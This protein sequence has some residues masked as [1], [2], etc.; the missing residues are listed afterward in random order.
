MHWWFC[1][2]IFSLYANVYAAD[3]QADYGEASSTLSPSLKE[4]VHYRQDGDNLIG[5]IYVGDH[6]SQ[7]SQATWLYIKKALEYYKEKRPAFII[8]RLNTPGGQVY[9]AQQIADALRDID[10]KDNIPVVAFIDDWAL[11][12]GAMLAYA[13]RYITTTTNGSMGAAE[14]VIQSAEGKMESASEK[15]N[16]AMRADFANRARTFNRD[17]NIAEAMVDKDILLVWRQGKVVRLDYTDQVIKTGPDP[18]IVITPSGKLLTLNAIEMM[19]YGVADLLLKPRALPAITGA[20]EEKGAWPADKMLLF[21]YPFFKDIPNA[22][23]DEYKMDWKTQLFVWLASPVISSLLFMGLLLGFYIE[24]NTPGFGVAGVAA[25]TC[26]FLIGLSS[27]SLEIA[28]WLELILL[29]TGLAFMLSEI[30]FMH[31][32][33]IMGIVGIFF[34]FAG[35]FGMLLPNI[36]KVEFDWDTTTFNAAGQLFFE[37]LAWLS[38][39]LVISLL[40]IG[41]ISRYIVPRFPA[42]KRFVLTGGEQDIQEGYVAGPAQSNMLSIGVKGVVVSAL[43]PAGKISVDDKIYQAMTYGVF[44]AEGSAVKVVGYDSGTVIVEETGEG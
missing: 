44:L 39:T 40:L 6:S 30:F 8:L 7:I 10:L 37:R 2:I 20:E 36:D 3:D 32:H 38:G 31:T 19:K 26:L 27:L 1:L 28:N 9:P 29:V 12:A 41:L 22:V 25:L 18:D 11:S 43:R 5:Y 15:V 35:L 14:P 21:Q 13:C 17:P 23:V 16:S 33:G 24:I 4:H 42:F 34:F